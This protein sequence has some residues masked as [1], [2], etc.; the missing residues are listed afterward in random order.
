MI[1]EAPEATIRVWGSS[2]S[3]YREASQDGSRVIKE[4]GNA[5]VADA[6]VLGDFP[7]PPAAVEGVVLDQVAKGLE[8]KREEVD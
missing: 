1:L 8:R 2:V 4:S 5:M 7:H 6:Y 3:G